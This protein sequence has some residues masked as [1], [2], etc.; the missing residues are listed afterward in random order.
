MFTSQQYRVKAT[1]YFELAKGA[2]SPNEL[3][4]FQDLGRSFIELANN[5]QWV[6]DNYD[7]TLH[8]ASHDEDRGRERA[9]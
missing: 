4:E 9:P 3:R 6:A 5:A 2:K 7:Q 1:E 8:A